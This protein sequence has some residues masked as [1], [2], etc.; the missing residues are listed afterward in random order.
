[1]AMK[2]TVGLR[3]ALLILTL[4]CTLLGWYRAREELQ[5]WSVDTI[6]AET[7]REL[8]QLEIGTLEER[9]REIDAVIAGKNAQNG[10]WAESLRGMT[11]SDLAHLR[12][13]IQADKA[14]RELQ[15]LGC[16]VN[17]GAHGEVN[18]SFE[19][20]RL[21]QADADKVADM[22]LAIHRSPVHHIGTLNIANAVVPPRVERLKMYVDPADD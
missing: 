19:Q 5:R 20:M 18:V 6:N 10:V 2:R 14:I 17:Y 11:P 8:I 12:K 21:N 13:H 7:K 4:A 16:G 15:L 9:M 1:M 22:L 3:L